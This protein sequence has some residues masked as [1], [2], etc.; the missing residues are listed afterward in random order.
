MPKYSQIRAQNPV[1]LP[2]SGNE[3][4]LVTQSG[5]TRGMIV[6][7]IQNAAVDST[8]TAISFD[9]PRIYGSDAQPETG[10]V[11]IVTTGLIKGMTQL[12]IHN[13]ASEPTFGAGLKIISGAYAT[14]ELNYILLLAV[15]SSSVLVSI[16]QEV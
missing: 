5:E 6:S 1:Q 11:T 8:G 2:L 16:T 4:L 15:S 12:L 3:I 13:N 10:N 9:R 7:E 14:G